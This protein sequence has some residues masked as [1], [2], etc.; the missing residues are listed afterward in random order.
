MATK[1]KFWQSVEKFISNTPLGM[2]ADGSLKEALKSAVKYYTH[3]GMTNDKR[4]EMA[5]QDK[6]LDE[7]REQ[8]YAVEKRGFEEMYGPEAQIKSEAAGYD[9]VGLNRMLM[10]GSSPGATASTPSPSAP[11]ASGGN[12]DPVAALMSVVGGFAQVRDIT[13]TADLKKSQKENQDIV[14]KWEEKNQEIK[15]KNELLKSRL[16]EVNIRKITADAENSEW[17]ALYAP[18]LFQ[19]QIDERNAIASKALSDI[20]KNVSD[21]AVND[22][23]IKEIDSIISKNQKEMEQIDALTDKIRQEYWNLVAEEDLTSAQIDECKARTAKWNEEVK[24]IASRIGLNEAD[25]Q[26][27]VWN[28]PRSSS[29][30]GFK[31][32]K[33]SF[34]GSKSTESIEGWSTPQLIEELKKRGAL[35]N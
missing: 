32:N 29:A 13:A 23:R 3:S 6:Y 33:S 18:D 7:N 15:Y 1:S 20:D 22:A 2:F 25:L 31:W 14:N 5:E 11:S 35:T 21:I 28:H 10:A 16:A 27:Y 24:E 26:W 8:D 17:L 30:F 19:S 12:G 9:A 34:T 4:E